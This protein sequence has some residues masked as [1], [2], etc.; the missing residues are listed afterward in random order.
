MIVRYDPATDLTART[1]AHFVLNLDFAQTFANLADTAAPQ[2]QGASLLP[3]LADDAT[4]WRT[5]FLIEHYE[6]HVQVP[7]YC[8]VRNQ[9][10]LYVEYETGEQELYDLNADPYELTNLAGDTASAATLSSLHTRM[11]QLCSPPPPGFT[12]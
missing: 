9:Q 10:Y 12:P 8:A 7:A 6:N 4:G 11:V 3:L 2:A 5:D 1:D